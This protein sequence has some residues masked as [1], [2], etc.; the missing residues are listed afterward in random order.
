MV[1][2]L[3]Y[4]PMAAL[5]AVEAAVRLESF[6][7][8]AREL[9][10][11]QS[12]ISQAVRQFEDRAGISLFRRSAG[13][14]QA[15]SAAKAY[16]ATVASALAAIREAGDGLATQPRP[17]VIGF[18]R[19]LL[20]SWLT[21][22]LTDFV[23]QHPGIPTSIIGL[24]RDF[25]EARQCDVS[26]IIAK[27]GNE[28]EGAVRFAREELIAV[29]TPTLAKTIGGLLEDHPHA[30]MP[31]LGNIWPRWRAA[32]GIVE[33]RAEEPVQFR[34]ISAVFGAVQMGQGVALIPRMVCGDAITRGELIEVSKITVHRDRS[35]WLL[36]SDHP[37]SRVFVQW[38][39]S[40]LAD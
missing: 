10:L 24:G 32:A 17:L 12:A 7:A 2:P 15:T 27:N 30:D 8:A 13:S 22:R 20:H 25:E 21:P 31:L 28:P 5:R 37:A 4:P 1:H 39:R 36:I 18:V 38:L 26:L 40:R 19:S 29:A 34:E 3:A 6:T 16:A 11:T 33:A 23:A 35:Y 9:N 14:L